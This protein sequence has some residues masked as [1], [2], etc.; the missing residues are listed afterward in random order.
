MTGYIKKIDKINFGLLSP[1]NIRD[2]SVVQ[3]ETPDTY[4]YD[5][6]PIEKGLMDSRLGVIDPNLVCRTCGFRGG[7]CQG[8]FGHIEL[9]LPIIHIG[10]GDV[11]HKIL[12]STCNECGRVLLSN[13]QIEEFSQKIHEAMDNRESLNNILKEVYK[14]A[15]I[16]TKNLPEDDEE[17]DPK[18]CCPHCG[19]PQEAIILDKPVTIRQG[20]YKLTASEV[21]ERLER[22]SDEDAFVLGVNPEVARPEWLVLTVLP[23]PPVTVRPSITLDTGE[24]S[25]DDLT[26]KLVDILRINQ[27][28]LENMEA[29]APQLIVEDLW[30]LL[31]YHVTTYFDNEASGVPPARHR[32]G[33][34]LKTLTQRLKG[35]EGRFRSNLSGKRVNF[36]ARTV[37]SPDPNISINEVGVPEMIAKEVT[38]PV[39]VNEWNMDEMVKYIQNG[40]DIHPG[41]NYV[42]RNDGRKIRVRNEETKELILEQLE[43][44]FIIERHL[45]DGDMV[46]FNRQPSLH[47]MSMMAHEV[48]VLPYK[49]FRLNLCVCPPYNA[50]FDGDE[51]NMHVFQTDESR[52]EAKSLM[53]VQEHILSPRFGGPIIGAIH[54]H[55][56]G[57]YLLTR[58]GVEFTEEQALQII[59]KSHLKL[60]TFKG[61]QWVLKDD[62]EFGEE[63]YIFKDEGDMWTGKE[64]FSLLL[65][66]DLNLSYSAEISKCP[67]VY[68]AEDATVVIKDGI[69]VQGV[70]DESAYGSFSGK[71]LDK[72]VKEYGPGRAK[73]F[74]DRST[75]LAICGIMKT[76]ITTSLNDEEIPEEAQDRINEHLDKKMDEVDKLVEAYEEGYLQALP[77]RSLEETLEMKIM[78]VL[79]EARDMSGSIAEN[80]LT[81]GK[82]SDD[83]PYDHVMAVENHSVVMA[84]T[85]A[86][87]SMLN[88]T[89]ITACVGQQAV[90]GGRIERGYLNRTLPHFKKG[91]LGA[92]AKGFVHSS[93]KSG[94]DPIEFFFHAMGGR[95]GLVDTAIR[96]AQSGYMQ[97]RLVNALQDLQVKPSG[98]VTDNQGN[99]IQ[100]MFGEDGVDPAKSDFGKPADLNDLINQIRA[101]HNRENSSRNGESQIIIV[102]NKNLINLKN[103]SKILLNKFYILE[104]SIQSQMS[105]FED[106]FD[107]DTLN[108]ILNK[109]H[110]IITALNNVKVINDSDKIEIILRKSLN[111]Y[112]TIKLEFEKELEKLENLLDEFHKQEVIEKTMH[113]DELISQLNQNINDFKI[114]YAYIKEKTIDLSNG[115]SNFIQDL[116]QNLH[117]ERNSLRVRFKKLIEVINSYAA[118]LN[119]LIKEINSI[120]NTYDDL[121]KYSEITDSFYND[122]IN[123]EHKIK[124]ANDDIKGCN[125][126]FNS[127][128]TELRSIKL[129]LDQLIENYNKL[130][131]SQDNVDEVYDKILKYN[132][133]LKMGII[134]QDEFDEIKRQI[135]SGRI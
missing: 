91:E 56:S 121:R 47:R 112:E 75:D 72:I 88:L 7:D 99:V 116:P 69:L 36:S 5:G 95:E 43:P 83:D 79:G 80:Y 119:N 62:P 135:I 85:G 130:N 34:P 104:N 113:F 4:E 68:P 94:L 117:V 81:M 122:V 106:I 98:L 124:K 25:E 86:R 66:N 20:D 50:D 120:E 8:H 45:K 89:Q 9:A 90:R 16:E 3:I 40:P 26:H 102:N 15:K 61:G 60:P 27:R 17:V 31:Q 70:I 115:F 103:Q 10:F 13:D 82:Q 92:K 63:S 23:V 107:I 101:E 126:Q 78:Q 28:L 123:L 14:I 74:L 129:G 97:R 55:I 132:N 21:R 114:S 64:L 41:A 42:I 1:E 118:R 53:R 109:L 2:M 22:I 133:L 59:R 67:V 73:E 48:R 84:R 49:T 57:A 11:I 46:L 38:V 51:M 108:S 58:D 105:K 96:T 134:T 35:K 30:E 18:H 65:P 24:R 12:R 127:I 76:G 87:A 111:S 131:D 19:A 44:G 37:I 39:Y 93:Y 54:D 77:G 128:K 29:G 125:I 110:N 52:A 33:R 6:Y 32:S 71:I 100:T